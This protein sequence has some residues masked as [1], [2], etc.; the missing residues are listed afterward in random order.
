MTT[1]H[2][3]ELIVEGL[4]PNN[5]DDL[6]RLYEHGLDDA[7]PSFISDVFIL[8]VDREAG[9]YGMALFQALRQ[10]QDAG[11]VVRRVLVDEDL[12]T[13]A[14][15]AARLDRTPE[16]VRLYITGDRGPG[17]FPQPIRRADGQP[18]TL[19]SWQEVRNWAIHDLGLDTEIPLPDGIDTPDAEAVAAM[20][21]AELQ[22]LTTIR[23]GASH[24][25][26]E[27]LEGLIAWSNDNH[28]QMLPA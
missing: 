18:S 3:F 1:T 7:T 15:I 13:R 14:D 8:T 10:V 19:W 12:V 5:D 11:G 9:S 4:D 26:N 28:L 17:G 25:D 22:A 2:R 24:L 20:V 16:S 21:N 27:A 23:A 6:D